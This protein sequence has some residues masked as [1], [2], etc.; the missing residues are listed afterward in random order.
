M[1][2]DAEM[3]VQA[4]RGAAALQESLSVLSQRERLFVCLSAVAESG[5][6]ASTCDRLGVSLSTAYE[7]AAAARRK[8]RRR[9]TSRGYYSV[10]DFGIAA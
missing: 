3:V 10:N 1:L 9:L 7:I 6:F 8:M 2:H 4:R 5:E